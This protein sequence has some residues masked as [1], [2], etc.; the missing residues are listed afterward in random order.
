MKIFDTHTHL[1][2]DPLWD[3][4]P[5]YLQTAEQLSVD[6]MAIVG[7]NQKF[8]QRAVQLAQQYAN[9]YAVIGWHPEDAD[10]YDEPALS[11]QLQQKKVVAIGEI[12]LDY[13]WE[14]NPS[15][16]EQHA[17]FIQQLE[18]AQQNSMPVNIHTRD[19]LAD[20]YEILRQH[21]VAHGM[22]MHSFNGSLYW[23][24][25]FLELGCYISYSGVVSFKNAPEVR[26]AALQTPLDRI[27]VETDAPYLTPEPHRGEKN[28]PAYAHYVAQAVAQTKNIPLATL[29]QAT[30]EN[31]HK[32]Y[33][34]NDKN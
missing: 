12:G 8:N 21:P 27:L 33:Q 9:L 16:K 14:Q 6:K 7:S 22:I 5:D 20:T 19:A 31:A 24:D 25:K 1:N 23:L 32:V 34:V 18:L 26:Q 4:V 15:A 30:W 13:H 28:Q 11:E 2:D 17:V 10:A 29:A 3:Q